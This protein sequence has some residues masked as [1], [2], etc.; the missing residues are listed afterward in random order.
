MKWGADEVPDGP[1]SSPPSQTVQARFPRTR[2]SSD[3]SAN[4]GSSGR[5]RR[6]ALRIPS[7]H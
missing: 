6:S 1:F 4:G 7:C 5:E 2:L 3:S